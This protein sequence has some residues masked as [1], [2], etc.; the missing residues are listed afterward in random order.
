MGGTCPGPLTLSVC[1]MYC[2]ME[3]RVLEEERWGSVQRKGGKRWKVMVVTLE[4]K[5]W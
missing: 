3:R 1:I 4:M 5:G 2:L